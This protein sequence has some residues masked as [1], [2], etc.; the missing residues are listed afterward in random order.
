M[1]MKYT[2]EEFVCLLFFAFLHWGYINHDYYLCR[3]LV[4][5]TGRGFLRSAAKGCACS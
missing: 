2:Q 4:P 3:Q 1:L 5:F